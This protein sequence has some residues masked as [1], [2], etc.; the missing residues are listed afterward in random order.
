MADVDMSVEEARPGDVAERQ[1]TMDTAES[2]AAAPDTHSSKRKR[3]DA[4]SYRVWVRSIQSKLLSLGPEAAPVSGA[5]Q[6]QRRAQLLQELESAY[7][8][9]AQTIAL[10][11]QEWQLLLNLHTLR[12]LRLGRPLSPQELDETLGL[13]VSATTESVGLHSSLFAALCSLLLALHSRYS[14]V[15][16]LGSTAS[17]LDTADSDAATNHATYDIMAP[18][19]GSSGCQLLIAVPGAYAPESIAALAPTCSQADAAGLR[20]DFDG[21]LGED[22]IRSALREACGRFARHITESQKIWQLYKVFELSLLQKDPSP[23]RVQE[24]QQVF[25]ARL[26]VPHQKIQSTFQSFSGFVTQRLPAKDYESTMAA[27]NKSYAATLQVLSAAEAFEDSLQGAGGSYYSGSGSAWSKYIISHMEPQMKGKGRSQK[28]ALDAD[29]HEAILALF[30]RCLA[31]FGLPL[32]TIEQELITMPPQ[33]AYEAERQ[34]REKALTRPEQQERAQQDQA[35]WQQAESL[36][37]DLGSFLASAPPAYQSVQ[38]LAWQKARRVM[39]DSGLLVAQQMRAYS[40]LRRPKHEVED[41][42]NAAVSAGACA[43]RGTGSLV[44]LLVGRV[45]VERE[46]AAI[47][48]REEMQQQHS[49]STAQDNGSIADFSSALVEVPRSETHWAEVYAILEYALSVLDHHVHGAGANGKDKRRAQRQDDTHL[50]DPDL[51]LQKYVSSWAERLGDAGAALVQPL[52][53]ALLESQGGTNIRVWHEAANFYKRTGDAS[54]AR[55]LFKQA[56]GRR[57]PVRANRG[58]AAQAS[59]G[60]QELLQAKTAL[61]QDWIT[62]EHEVGGAADVQHALARAK[63][64]TSKL[65]DA[66]YQRYNAQSVASLETAADTGGSGQRVA[67]SE[68][69]ETMP[70]VAAMTSAASGAVERA[71]AKRKAIDEGD[72]SDD[73]T[74]D[75]ESAADVAAGK[76]SRPGDKSGGGEGQKRDREHSSVV[77]GKLPPNATQAEL[78][79]L[80]HRCGPIQTITGPSVLADGRAAAIVEFIDQSSVTGA[81]T[82]NGKTLRDEDKTEIIVSLGHDCTLY[83]TNF[84]EQTTDSELRERFGK[85]GPIFGVRWP[86]KKF[87]EKRRFA[88]IQYAEPQCAKAALV[89]NGL[90]LSESTK[91][92]V[93]LSDPERRKK[94]SDANAN[95]K[96]L[97]VTG[98]PRNSTVPEEVRSLFEQYGAVDDVRIPVLKDKDGRVQEGQIQGIAF[99]DMHT[100]LDAQRAMR[101]LNSITY[102]GKVL[103]VTLAA[104]R[105]AGH[106]KPAPTHFERGAGGAHKARTVVVRGLPLDAQEGLIQQTIDAALGTPGGGSVKQVEWTPGEEGKGHAKVELRDASVAG[107]LLLLP[108]LSYDGSHPLSV[109][110]LGQRGGAVDPV[111]KAATSGSQTA[112]NGQQGG[113]SVQ[114]SGPTML[115]PRATLGRGRGRGGVA[116]ARPTGSRPTMHGSTPSSTAAAAT[117][118]DSMD[119]DAPA[120][121]ATTAKKG[122]NDFRAMLGG[123]E[124]RG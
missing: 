45:D 68:H 124:G 11:E 18:W 24:V 81:L 30:E 123:G 59:D 48:I 82:R 114:P 17:I 117:S 74:H 85:Y 88:Y 20:Q 70:V 43:A 4:L 107:K 35:R 109:I 1:E 118:S 83:V 42:F 41:L 10:S 55:M 19:T 16:T 53:E 105:G 50:P 91:L 101:E 29:D 78:R 97:Y 92:F 52:W 34:R 25:L 13:H 72:E 110:P 90:K 94:R 99:I 98:L 86:S 2:E 80:F 77:V 66:Y 67:G 62:F 71:S 28:M 111:Q 47:A 12:R 63:V 23:K 73:G 5:E 106:A 93:A 64:E 95:L 51:T 6:D 7:R 39:P 102:R 112:R 104:P 37:E 60:M 14:E 27:A 38:L 8:E 61:L 36:W 57:F 121:E 115:L 119:V 32:T 46:Y 49:D 87:A 100:D 96:E 122:Q 89:E 22:A 65:W 113:S 75:A 31:I 40:A 54:R 33:A 9:T 44:K 79:S 26:K 21:R 58:G 76:K 120:S 103:S 116:F 84:P 69:D 108:G 15:A 56:S 3:Q